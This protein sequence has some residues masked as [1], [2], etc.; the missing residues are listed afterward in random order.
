MM[1]PEEFEICIVAAIRILHV[2]AVLD[3]PQHAYKHNR[4]LYLY[5]EVGP[6]VLPHVAGLSLLDP[7]LLETVQIW[8]CESVAGK[9]RAG[10]PLCRVRITAVNVCAGA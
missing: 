7:G 9:R 10:T 8:V 1:F 6:E 2:L 5:F 4:T 3:H